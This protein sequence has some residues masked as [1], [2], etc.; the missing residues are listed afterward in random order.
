MRSSMMLHV[1]KVR[2]E[3]L[4]RSKAHT[5][6]FSYPC[7]SWLSNYCLYWLQLLTG[8]SPHVGSTSILHY[9]GI[10]GS[11]ESGRMHTQSRATRL[12]SWQN[13]SFAAPCVM[14][15]LAAW[16]AC[17]ILHGASMHP[18][19]QHRPSSCNQT[20][21]LEAQPHRPMRH[22][23][24]HQSQIVSSSLHSC[25]AHACRVQPALNTLAAI[26]NTT[27]ATLPS[28]PTTSS[29]PNASPPPTGAADDHRP[30]AQ[31]QC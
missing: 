31:A 29:D 22:A 17:C 12:C 7:R 27:R 11:A 1:D 5:L 26:P 24:Q 19:L 21:Q 25:N 4:D 15:G 8:I 18:Q 14:Y 10:A 6:D 3:M 16:S 2:H 13:A 20:M 9:H 28:P 23:S 30:A